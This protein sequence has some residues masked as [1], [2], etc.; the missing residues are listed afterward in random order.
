[1]ARLTAHCF[2]RKNPVEWIY[3]IPIH[4]IL[5]Q[6]GFEVIVVNARDAKHVPERQTDVSDARYS[7][8]HIQHRRI[9]ST[10]ERR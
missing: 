2:R 4:E 9:F 3:W 1:M 5:E 6:R 8:T 10:C 7:A